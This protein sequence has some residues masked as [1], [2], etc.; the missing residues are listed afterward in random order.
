M[1]YWFVTGFSNFGVHLIDHSPLDVYHVDWSPNLSTAYSSFLL[2]YTFSIDIHHL[3]TNSPHSVGAYD[4]VDPLILSYT[5]DLGCKNL[6]R[7]SEILDLFSLLEN[8]WSLHCIVS[9]EV[10]TLLNTK[11]AFLWDGL[12]SRYWRSGIFMPQICHHHCSLTCL[13]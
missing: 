9:S 4:M 5:L 10:Q 6:M 12:V 2:C 11:T 7:R 13:L 1:S 3:P 8:Y